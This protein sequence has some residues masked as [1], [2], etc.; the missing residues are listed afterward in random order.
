M[1]DELKSDIGPAMPPPNKTKSE[2]Q[3]HNISNNKKPKITSSFQNGDIVKTKNENEKSDL[4]ELPNA[5]HYERS[6]MHRANVTHVAFSKT[7][8]A[9]TASADG[10][11]KFWRRKRWQKRRDCLEFVKEFKAHKGALSCLVLSGDGLQLATASQS[12]CFVRF[13]DVVNFDMTFFAKIAVRP[14][15]CEWIHAGRR[16]VSGE[17]A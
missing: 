4:D 2:L 13:F 12:D 16:G 9:V 6:F 17:L 5:R 14:T 7:D 15:C 8:F 11:V 3:S 1:S 10:V